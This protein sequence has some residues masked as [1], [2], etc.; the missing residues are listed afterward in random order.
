MNH[1]EY[2][3]RLARKKRQE[4]DVQNLGEKA[5]ALIAAAAAKTQL[6]YEGLAKDDPLLYGSEAVLDPDAGR[7]WFRRDLDPTLRS[8]YLAHEYAHYWLEGNT[9]SCNHPN[10]EARLGEEKSPMGTDRVEN[11]SPKERREA[12]ANVFAREFLLPTDRLRTWFVDQHWSASAIGEHVGLPESLVFN[13]LIDALL[14]TPEGEDALAVPPTIQAERIVLDP[15]QLAAATVG[16]GPLLVEA[17]PGTGKT[18]TLIGRIAHLV[19][20]QKVHPSSILVLTFSNKAAEEMRERLAQV[21]PG[22]APSVWMGTFHAFGLELLRKY[23]HALA[24]PPSPALL[25]PVAALLLMERLLPQMKLDHYQN[26]FDPLLPLRDILQAI[27]RAKDE[28]VRPD[29]YREMAEAMVQQAQDDESR[30]RAEEA[31]EVAGVYAL[32][33]AQLDHEQLLDFGDLIAKPVELLAARDDIRHEIRDQYQHVLV[34][35]YQDVNRACA[36]FLQQLAG[37]GN[38]L[39]VVGDARQSIYRFRGAAP[40]NVAW[41]LTDFPGA[42][43][44]SLARNYRSQPK[45]LA[46]YA[47]LARGMSVPNSKPFEDWEP[48]RADEGGAALLEQAP[49]A[50]AEGAA[51][52]SEIRELLTQ[53]IPY[54]DQAILCRSHTQLERISALLER[55]GIP[56][57]YV[58]DLFERPEI[59]DLLALVA[60]VAG[61]PRSLI[62]IGNFAEYQIPAADLRMLCSLAEA[63]QIAFPQA[64][65]RLKDAPALSESARSSLKLLDEHL[66]DLVY[67]H[68]VWSLL[69]HYLFDR[70]A[71]LRTLMS[72]TDQSALQQRIAIYQFLRFASEQE[73]WLSNGENLKRRFLDYVRRLEVFGEEKQLRQIPETAQTMDAVRLL[74]IHASKGL[75]FRAVYLPVLGKGLMPARMQAQACPPPAGMVAQDPKEAHEEE[76][77]CLFFVGLSRARDWLVLSRAE[78]YNGRGSNPSEFLGL[79]ASAPIQPISHQMTAAVGQQPEEQTSAKDK[80]LATVNPLPTFEQEDLDLYLRCPRRYYYDRVFSLAVGGEDSVFLQFHRCL[81][82]LLEWMEQQHTDTGQV[83]PTDASQ[84]LERLWTSTSLVGHP[85]EALYRTNAQAMAAK[86]LAVFS[87]DRKIAKNEV[88]EVPFQHGAVRFSIDHSEM[89]AGKRVLRRMK[90]GRIRSSEANQN[91]YGLYHTAGKQLAGESY[92]VEVFSLSTGAAE[93]IELSG[94]K[95]QTLLGHYEAAIDGILTEDYRVDPADSRTCPR[96]PYYFVCPALPGDRL[97]VA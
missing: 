80:V 76:E 42:K 51:I 75:E 32:Y 31:L 40:R 24:L 90:T 81:Y 70:S 86:A 94:R 1:W 43:A 63:E 44:T 84:E 79:L 16:G 97:S 47:A 22:E 68:G 93:P 3:R 6:P 96:C 74:T 15:S 30:E 87:E 39:W 66:Q 59:R 83:K 73:Q 95:L 48:E 38:G 53:G 7:V 61:D 5:E 2:A 65:G 14:P 12:M 85:L 82:Q 10:L 62:R 23:G 91:V 35:E 20:E 92:Q 8:L 55:D 52:A 54:K 50:G 41:F 29:K 78:Q 49:D 58:G 18:R 26:L 37:D 46:T 72:S 45:L 17:G 88:L 19:L 71:Y 33:Q 64:I 36:L 11:Y 34:D 21:L 89:Q 28:L 77:V 27:S 56:I 9:S 4:I 69:V 13:Q 25:D 67:G 60:L 57:L